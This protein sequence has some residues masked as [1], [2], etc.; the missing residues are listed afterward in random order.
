MK[1]Y[2]SVKNT[3]NTSD[4]DMPRRRRGHVSLLTV[5][6]VAVL[7]LACVICVAG[8]YAYKKFTFVKV[9]KKHMTIASQITAV[10][11]LTTLKNNYSDVVC[12]KKT[13]AAGLAKSYSIV[14]YNGV[15]R[16][17]IKDASQIKVSISS[18]GKSVTVYVPKSEVLG[19]GLV[20]QEVFDEKNSIFV[21]ITTA[22][23]FDEIQ[24]GMVA[25]QEACIKE[26]FLEESDVQVKKVVTA[27]LATCGFNQ[28]NV[29]K[30]Y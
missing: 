4:D 19:N 12:V 1:D 16:A 23:I 3:K 6:I 11:E 28:I 2:H 24:K 10:A 15:L 8:F 29:L 25:T 30:K 7:V 18:D 21:P 9:E 5:K 26:G 17:G 22:E 14:K 13:G 27:F 20:S